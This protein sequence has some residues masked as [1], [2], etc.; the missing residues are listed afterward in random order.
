MLAFPLVEMLRDMSCCFS[1]EDTNTD[2]RHTFVCKKDFGPLH[3]CKLSSYLSVCSLWSMWLVVESRG[4][5]KII[6]STKGGRCKNS[7]GTN[8]SARHK[9]DAVIF[10]LDQ[11]RGLLFDITNKIHPKK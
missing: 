2:T 4:G 5:L 6:L 10:S 11:W 3:V 9:H 1:S 7:V 8:D